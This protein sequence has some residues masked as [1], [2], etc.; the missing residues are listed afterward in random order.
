MR[1]QLRAS[2]STCMVC[3]SSHL[4]SRPHHRQPV[5]GAVLERG[6]RSEKLGTVSLSGVCSGTS[7]ARFVSYL[8]VEPLYN[9]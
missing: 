5:M 6:F 8:Q 1:L 9:R 4:R 2:S 7:M 3:V